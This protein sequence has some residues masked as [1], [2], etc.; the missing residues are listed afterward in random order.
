MGR[1]CKKIR[2]QTQ[3]KGGLKDLLSLHPPQC[4]VLRHT[5]ALTPGVVGIEIR[6][7][8]NLLIPSP[9]PK[10]FHP[11]ITRIEVYDAVLVNG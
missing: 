2:V 11:W 1:A 5:A 8:E 6:R 7:P 4:K 9:H 3:I 10:T